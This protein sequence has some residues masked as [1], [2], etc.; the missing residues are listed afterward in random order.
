MAVHLDGVVKLHHGWYSLEVRHQPTLNPDSVHLSINVPEGWK[1]DRAPKMQIPYS[2][3]A[4]LTTSG[5][6]RTTTFRVHLVRDPDSFDLW[7]RLEA[8]R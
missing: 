4:S 2:R 5:L 6:D 3:R 1:I 7:D 8:G